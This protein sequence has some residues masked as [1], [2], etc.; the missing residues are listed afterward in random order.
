MKNWPRWRNLKWAI[1]SQ[2]HRTYVADSSFSR[3]LSQVGSSVN[4]NLKRCP[5]R[6]QCP[7]NSPTIHLNW[8]LFNFN[9]SFVL[10]A[11]G[12]D[13]SPFACSSP[14]V[15]SHEPLPGNGYMRHNI[16]LVTDHI[17]TYL[18]KARTVT[19][20]H[21]PTIIN[22]RRSGAFSVPSRAVTSR[23]SPRL[24]CCQATA[25]N[26]WMTQEWG[27][28]T[29][30]RQHWRHAFQQW[31]NKWS[32][33]RVPVQGF[34]GETEASSGGVIGQFSVGDCRSSR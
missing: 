2:S 26:T 3:H 8:S 9:R 16:I 18:R 25:I 17:V 31:R 12:P 20:K 15:D 29:W 14:V 10:L 7:V 4:P 22:R 28:V 27:R 34:I 1:P 32:V 19:S 24:V 21:A 23:A 11:E 5:F 13:M 33:S 6:R 30:P